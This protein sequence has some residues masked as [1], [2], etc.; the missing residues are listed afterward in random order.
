MNLVITGRHFDLTENLKEEIHKKTERF[1]RYF[2]HIIDVHV[3][4]SREKGRYQ[5]EIILSAK[6][7]I[8]TSKEEGNDLYLCLN[9]AIEKIETQLSHLKDKI[10]DKP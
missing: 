8:C 10:K 7:L 2:S 5:V 9:K 4:I 6:K 3:V 1:K